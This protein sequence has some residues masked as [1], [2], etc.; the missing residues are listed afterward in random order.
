MRRSL[1]FILITAILAS[2]LMTQGS[3]VYAEGSKS[4]AD[5]LQKA[6]DE[7]K[8]HF[9]L[10][11]TDKG[12]INES[13]AVDGHSVVGHPA[14][15][16]FV[17]GSGA[18]A[19]AEI[20]SEE[21]RALGYT[22]FGRPFPNPDFPSDYQS[23]GATNTTWL[24]VDEIAD[25][26]HSLI[27]KWIGDM[28]T[29]P[30]QSHFSDGYL[31][32]DHCV[33]LHPELV[34]RCQSNG[35]DL[36]LADYAY[37]MQP[38]TADSWGLVIFFHN[39]S[40]HGILYTTALI[41][42]KSLVS[43]IKAKF[44][45]ISPFVPSGQPVDVKILVDS[46]FKVPV[47]TKYI[48]KVTDSG[49]NVI[50]KTES[51][52]N[53]A[54]DDDY[55]YTNNFTM[56]SSNV[57]VYFEVNPE[58][59]PYEGNMDN[60]KISFVSSYAA[61]TTATGGDIVVDY[62]ILQKYA[63]FQFGEAKSVLSKPDE[64]NWNTSGVGSLWVRN[65]TTNIYRRHCKNCTCETLDAEGI[66]ATK[67]TCNHPT[68][69]NCTE[70]IF[71]TPSFVENP[72]PG[73]KYEET[74][75]ITSGASDV[76]ISRNPE[77][78]VLLRREDFGD[79]PLA[80]VWGSTNTK[81]GK[82][83]L[84]GD[85]ER[86]WI[87]WCQH[88]EGG[89][90]VDG[91]SKSYFA[92]VTANKKNVTVKV[93]NGMTNVPEPTVRSEI[94]NNNTSSKT[95]K[96]WWK[97]TPLPINVVRLMYTEKKD[98]SLTSR[99]AVNGKNQRSFVEQNKADLNW[100]ISGGHTI[101]NDLKDDRE[102]AK[103]NNYKVD[104]AKKAVFA[105]DVSYKNMLHPI[106]SGYFFNPT[107]TYTFTIKTEMYKN[108]AVQT[109]EHKDL[110]DAVIGSFRYA[111]DM[112]YINAA[113]KKAVGIDNVLVNKTG[114]TY[115]PRKSFI[116]AV[117]NELVGVNVDRNYSLDL[118]EELGHKY[119]T[120]AEDT[121]YASAI[122]NT[123][124]DK[125]FKSVLE[126]YSESGTASSRSNYRYTEYVKKDVHIYKI[127]ETTTVTITVNPNNERLYTHAQMKDGNYSVYAYIDNINL[128]ALSSEQLRN[129]NGTL[130]GIE[131]LDKIDINVVGSIYEDQ[132]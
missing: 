56:P 109:Q 93:Y 20:G 1:V 12:S 54:A 34:R 11:E 122:G 3:A 87:Y 121:A 90:Y 108:T 88:E 66:V 9:F 10:K 60:N 39:T 21:D 30:F 46:T 82:A 18:V 38:S 17:Y 128:N 72:K 126:G 69:S 36:N 29:S 110:V 102:R 2:A 115:A 83:S 104:A 23:T 26:N 75:N 91:S 70:Q 127:T 79:N 113:T 14:K 94:E 32:A 73:A 103:A 15:S 51:N 44:L 63:S 86:G 80:G 68:A 58:G 13:L 19:S 27:N 117:G 81:E 123:V 106:R 92:G 48:F 124:T 99:N 6:N 16:F 71:A 132:R 100:S 57:T 85:L 40:P 64:A 55:T 112:T 45:L 89:H 77:I 111:S 43:D 118:K 114:A 98:G 78:H 35:G 37:V 62:N 8:G 22:V 4:L 119:A 42:P 50:K 33:D 84:W 53:I 31:I 52:L 61:V 116:T 95:K 101:A 41:K 67:C 131:V 96:L 25:K 49:G 105:S 74:L 7:L 47:N 107:G 120:L 97:S 24:S 59:N 76:T 130:N 65:D 28:R 125:R 129:L 5:V